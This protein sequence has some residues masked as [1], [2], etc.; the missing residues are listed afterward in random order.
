MKNGEDFLAYKENSEG[1][2]RKVIFEESF[3]LIG[4]NAKM[5]I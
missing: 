5:L 4:G 2:G 1:I 3:P